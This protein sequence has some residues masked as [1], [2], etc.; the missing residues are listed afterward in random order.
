MSK[1]ELQNAHDT[2]TKALTEIATGD[3]SC[4]VFVF[5]RTMDSEGMASM[6][7]NCTIDD[8]I[9][10]TRSIAEAFDFEHNVS[11]IDDNQMYG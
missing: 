5:D 6:S 7:K 8:A 3:I 11:S 2:M 4:I 10:M 9:L 1:P